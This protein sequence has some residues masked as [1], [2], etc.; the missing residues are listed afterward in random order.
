MRSYDVVFEFEGHQSVSAAIASE[1][2][3]DL[4]PFLARVNINVRDRKNDI[5]GSGHNCTFDFNCVA[6]QG[7]NVV[8]VLFEWALSAQLNEDDPFFSY[9]QQW[10]LS[11]KAFNT[12]HKIIASSLGLDPTYFSTHSSRVGGA[13]T[14]AAAGFPDSFI[15][16]AGGWNSLAFLFFIRLAIAQYQRGLQALSNPNI[17]T[18]KDVKKLI[19]GF[20][21][22]G[23]RP[24]RK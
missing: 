18:V 15:M 8:L 5:G 20:A 3:A 7:F 1:V 13:C 21:L 17:F 16:L 12:A 2:T 11:Y 4:K 23:D 9:R 24:L 6:T 10:K 14:L 19:P 22:L